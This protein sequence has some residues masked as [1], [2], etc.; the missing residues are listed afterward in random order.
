MG[1]KWKCTLGEL[2]SKVVLDA[3]RAQIIENHVEFLVRILS[4]QPIH[5]L[6]KFDAAL[7]FKMPPDDLASG[8]VERREECAGAMAFVFM[9]KAGQGA[10][11]RHLEPA[12][13]PLQGLDAGLFVKA[14]D[15]R[16]FWRRQVKTDDIG[17][18]LGELGIGRD[19]PTAAAF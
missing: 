4:H 2:E 3:V 10:T 6:Q 1:V 16:M 14:Q 17:R 12:L 19:A 15:H 11:I 7:A 18:F 9:G 5:E 13:R 8:D